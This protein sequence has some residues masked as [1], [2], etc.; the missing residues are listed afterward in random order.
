[1]FIGN[2]YSSKNERALS[3]SKLRGS[4]AIYSVYYFYNSHPHVTTWAGGIQILWNIASSL[5]GGQF[6][7]HPR[8]GEK[9]FTHKICKM[10]NKN[11]MGVLKRK[12]FAFSIKLSWDDFCLCEVMTH[13][14]IFN[15]SIRVSHS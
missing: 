3:L 8:A 13:H 7:T 4:L 1:M 14:F 12:N 11:F 15:V 5:L 6:P 2:L 9:K 10:P